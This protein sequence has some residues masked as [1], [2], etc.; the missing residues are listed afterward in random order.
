MSSTGRIILLLLSFSLT[1]CAFAALGTSAAADPDGGLWT[2]YAEQTGE[3][4]VLRVARFD[5]VN[6]VWQP[7]LRVNERPEPISADGE[8]RPKLAFG[9]RGELYVS[10]TSPT[11]AKYTGDIRFARSLD[12]GKT[13]SA[14][15]TVHRDRQRI[16]HRFE[17]LL[18]DGSGKIWIAWL[19]KRDLHAA[20]AAKRPYAG[21]AMYYAFS[22]D[23]GNSWQGDFKLADHSCECCRIAMTLDQNG[24]PALMWRHVFEANQRDH[25]FAVL[26]PD[27]TAVLQRVTFDRWAID[28][29]PHHGPSVAIGSDGTR[30]A[31]WFTQIGGAGRVYYGQLRDHSPA[32]VRELPSGASHAD[33]VASGKRVAI[34]WK[35]FDG[36]ATRIETLVSHDGGASFRDGPVLRT[37]GESDQPRLVSVGSRVRLVWRQTQQTSVVDLDTRTPHLEAVPGKGSSTM[38]YDSAVLP[39][40]RTTLKAIEHENHGRAFWVLLWDLECTYCMKSMQHAVEAQRRRPDLKIV[41]IATDSVTKA[42][43]LRSRLVELGLHSKAYAFAQ[44]PAEALRYVIDPQWAGEKPR[45]YRYAMTGEREAFS[46]VLSVDALISD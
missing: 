45:A 1:P 28:A 40:E 21:A 4:S 34:A 36:R 32:N 29:C 16:S 3:N 13:W 23:R 46:G 25:A 27:K 44:D 19:D 17:S 42:P 30:H 43:A 20:E 5:E 39:F 35:R 7:A 15:T 41:T 33:I 9:L 10:W 26:E 22:S 6:R 12:S 24:R 37:E 18:V 11:S 2:A 31:V 38:S 14:P 8:N